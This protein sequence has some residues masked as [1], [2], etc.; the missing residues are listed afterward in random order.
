MTRLYSHTQALCPFCLAKVPARIV[1]RDAKV[2]LEKF[3]ARHGFSEAMISSDTAWYEASMEYVKPK[4]QPL[5]WN[6]PEFKGCPESC[7]FCP[8]HQQ[9]TCLPVIEITSQCNLQCPVCL[10]HFKKPFTLDFRQFESILKN[11]AVSEKTLDVINLSGGEPTL[12][13]DLERFIKTA[14]GHGVTQITVSTNGL[15]LLDRKDLRDLFKKTGTIAAL[16]FDGFRPESYQ[17]L[18]GR[19]L[20]VQKQ[21][22]IRICEAEGIRYSLVA[23]IAA[24]LNQTE[25]SGMVDFFFTSGAVSLMFQPIA[26]IGQAQ[27]LSR[28]WRITIPDIVAEI[29]KSAYVKKGDFNPLP[30]SHFSCFALSYYF[31]TGPG[32]FINLKE[33]L[34]LEAYLDLIANKTLP[35]LDATGFQTIREKLYNLWSLSDSVS[36]DEQILKRIRSVLKEMGDNCFNPQK[37]LALG[38]ESMKAIFI[39]DF[40]DRETFDFGRVIKCCNPY[41]QPDGRLIPMCVQN[42]FFQ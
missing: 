25:I 28:E 17:S 34:G 20:S 7:G 40:M 19:D 33:F 35:G 18:R 42:V 37:A 24:G 14:Q 13:P 5:Q 2:F 9:H 6:V 38:L 41:P 22:L 3:C 27:E 4:Q 10:K 8:E 1:S 30:C 21:E 36:T 12:H 29:E 11:L 39:H 32:R 15:L 26:F 16:Q 23:T 31:I